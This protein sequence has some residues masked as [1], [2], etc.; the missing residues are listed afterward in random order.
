[1]RKRLRHS[2]IVGRLGRK[3][4]MVLA[5]SKKHRRFGFGEWGKRLGF[6][7]RG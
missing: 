3:R 4:V 5:K 2:G 1:M 6:G 7:V